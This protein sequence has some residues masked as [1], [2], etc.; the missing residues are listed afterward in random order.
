MCQNKRILPRNCV[1]CEAKLIG[2]SDK[3]YCSLECKNR[4]HSSVRKQF[5]SI[6][7]ETVRIL[8]RNHHI[9]EGLMTDKKNN[10]IIDRLALERLGFKLKYISGVTLINSVM[11]YSV[12]DYSYTL[13]TDNRIIVTA[14]KHRKPMSPFIFKRWNIIYK[15][16]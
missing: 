14:S 1:I 10:F 2:R 16:L 8:A 4:Y 5:K 13:L 3:V 7:S 9:L 11:S 15:E 12:F 6:S